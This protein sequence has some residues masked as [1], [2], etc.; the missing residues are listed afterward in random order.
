MAEV[1]DA[2]SAGKVNIESADLKVADVQENIATVNTDF[3]DI[4]QIIEEQKTASQKIAS[5]GTTYYKTLQQD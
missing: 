3:Q 1:S 4:N 5:V 2:V